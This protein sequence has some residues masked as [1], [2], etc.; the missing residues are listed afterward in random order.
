MNIKMYQTQ[1]V[2]QGLWI[3]SYITLSK[4]LY[5]STVSFGLFFIFVEGAPV[6]KCVEV[7]NYN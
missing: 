7:N 5:L 2:K 4:F 1:D 3:I 6:P